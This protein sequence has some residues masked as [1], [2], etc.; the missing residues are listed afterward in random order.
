[1]ENLLS[2][3]FKS[4]SLHI[5][6]D[7][8]NLSSLTFAIKRVQYLR[9]FAGQEASY[10]E[11]GKISRK[12]KVANAFSRLYLFWQSRGEIRDCISSGV[13]LI[14]LYSFLDLLL[15]LFIV[16]VD[17]KVA[18]CLSIYDLKINKLVEI[19]LRGIIRRVDHIF[20]SSRFVTDQFWSLFSFP[21]SR[22]TVLAI[23]KYLERKDISLVSLPKNKKDKRN[24]HIGCF[25]SESAQIGHYARFKSLIN[26]SLSESDMSVQLFLIKNN[27]NEEFI[28]ETSSYEKV[29]TIIAADDVDLLTLD[30]W[31]VFSSQSP[32]P[33]INDALKIG[34]RVIAPSTHYTSELQRILNERLLTYKAG[35]VSSAVRQLNSCLLDMKTDTYKNFGLSNSSWE[36]E[37]HY[38]LDG[39]AKAVRRRQNLS[40]IS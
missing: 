40:R 39:Y 37:R 20:V 14:H 33:Y 19:L 34:A 11:L 7:H 23:T 12:G 22:C 28:P 35:E 16:Q 15:L 26:S 36:L 9:G 25:L 18:I 2:N 29:K 8:L 30:F 10:I 27:I 21:P 4:Q 31:L 24:I 17:N 3:K 1:M 5:I 38:L 6:G 13:N 32:C